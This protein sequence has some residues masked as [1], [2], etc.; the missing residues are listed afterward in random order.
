MEWI[1]NI[2]KSW[3]NRPR[4]RKDYVSDRL[5]IDQFTEIREDIKHRYKLAGFYK[6]HPELQIMYA[7]SKSFSSS[8]GFI[9]KNFKGHLNEPTRRRLRTIIYLYKK[10]M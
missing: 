10:N 2:F 3:R 8:T 7:N 6:Q 5:L 9:I 1:R 4:K